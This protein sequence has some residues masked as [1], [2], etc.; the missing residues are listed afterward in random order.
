MAGKRKNKKAADENVDESCGK[1][2]TLKRARKSDRWKVDEL[3]KGMLN[4]LDEFT[5]LN[6]I[7]W[8]GEKKKTKGM[9]VPWRREKIRHLPTRVLS[10]GFAVN[11]RKF[12][13]EFSWTKILIIGDKKKNSVNARQPFHWEFY[14]FWSTPY[15]QD[16]T[17]KTPHLWKPTIS[18][19]PNHVQERVNLW[20]PFWTQYP[21]IYLEPGMGK[22][23][24]ARPVRQHFYHP[25]FR[26]T[27]NK[28]STLCGAPKLSKHAYV[29]Q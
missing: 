5:N 22:G 11:K 24:E 17:K 8:G 1:G 26:K 21:I 4:R 16:R 3:R 27:E 12:P 7:L 23:T 2:G 13:C 25:T 18:N 28:I 20:K 10:R 19:Y 29:K 6:P 14:W 9:L 15:S